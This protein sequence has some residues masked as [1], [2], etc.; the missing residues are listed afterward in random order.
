M[1]KQT[2]INNFMQ[3]PVF[4]ISYSPI[5]E[6]GMKGEIPKR[7]IRENGKLLYSSR[8]MRIHPLTNLTEDEANIEVKRLEELG[9]KNVKKE[10]SFVDLPRDCPSCKKPGS[11]S[12]YH[13]KRNK[14]KSLK[15]ESTKSEKDILRYNHSDKTTCYIGQIEFFEKERMKVKIKVKDSIKTDAFRL[16]NRFSF[17]KKSM[18]SLN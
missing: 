7:E 18:K 10:K 4:K 9:Y 5:F 17:K 1:C 15:F 13:Q 6:K 16:R 8:Q 12:I 3:I 11:P 14:V 2:A